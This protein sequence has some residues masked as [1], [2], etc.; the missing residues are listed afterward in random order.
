MQYLALASDFDGTIA[1]DGEIDEATLAALQRWRQAERQIILITGRRLDDFL[2]IFAP[3]Q[4]FDL[5]VA[6]NGAVLY[7]PQ[8][9]T[10]RLLAEPPHPDFVEQLRHRIAQANAQ[11]DTPHSIAGEF[12]Q[13]AKHYSLGGLEVG[14]VIVAT[15][16]PHDATAQALIEEQELALQVILNK[17][18]V[19]ILPD[20]IDK[21]FGLKAALQELELDPETVVG[22]GDA[23]N[24]AAFLHLCGHSVAVAN[25]L[26]ALKEQVD[27]VT[28]E[29]RGAGVTELIDRLLS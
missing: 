25:A 26:P 29:S 8:Q 11:A 18:A 27:F 24:D 21:A 12:S 23:E 9:Q 28:T 6:E 15:W 16:V 5:V 20:G 7:H 17:G 14:R 10:T 19:M 22:V 13:L 3:V 2:Q 4:I 1:K